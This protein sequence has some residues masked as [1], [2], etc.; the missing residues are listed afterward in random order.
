MYIFP[1][2]IS[3][4]K[5]HVHCNTGGFPCSFRMESVAWG[6]FKH[7]SYYCQHVT[8]HLT[9]DPFLHTIKCLSKILV[10]TRR[11]AIHLIC[12]TMLLLK[13]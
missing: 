13:Y 1:Y 8:V 3:S 10:I 7:W 12:K 4:N 2:L 9:T 6:F 11:V 5:M